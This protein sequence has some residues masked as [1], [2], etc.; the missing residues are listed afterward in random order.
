MKRTA[1]EEVTGIAEIQAP[2]DERA[3]PLVLIPLKIHTVM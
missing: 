2:L 1:I 3:Q